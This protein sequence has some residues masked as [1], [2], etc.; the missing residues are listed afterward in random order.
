MTELA[1]II[2]DPIGHSL[3]PVIHNA[4]YKQLGLDWHYSAYLVKKS[5]IAE[6]IRGALALSLRGLSVTMPHKGSVYALADRKSETV[7]QLGAAN[8]ISFIDGQ[9]VADSTDGQGL[10]DDILDWGFIPLNKKIVVLGTGGAARAAVL[11]L[12]NSGVSEV[13]VLGRRIEMAREVANLAPGR[14]N[15]GLIEDIKLLA[16]ADMFINATPVGMTDNNELSASR[17]NCLENILTERHWLFDMIYSPLE[18]PMMKMAGALGAKVRNGLGM[19]IH[20]AAIQFYLWTG[21][22]AP[23]QVMWEAVLNN[24]E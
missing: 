10:L 4:A 15:Y 16:K 22:E 24:I 1:G 2:G 13:V 7:E 21:Y 12:G 6:A 8:T 14:S 17:L 18:T 20:Q 5:N 23:I 3:S 19:L 9:I 11:A